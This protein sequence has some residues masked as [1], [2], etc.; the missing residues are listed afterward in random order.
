MFA[1]TM[2]LAEHRNPRRTIVGALAMIRRPLP[3][4]SL[5]IST[6]AKRLSSR[7]MSLSST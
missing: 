3:Y 7:S 4:T 6:A 2:T 5:I 1:K